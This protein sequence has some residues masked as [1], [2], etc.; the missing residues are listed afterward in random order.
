MFIGGFRCGITLGAGNAQLMRGGACA[1]EL[2]LMV[3]CVCCSSSGWYRLSWCGFC[4]CIFLFLVFGVLCV[5]WVFVY[6]VWGMGEESPSGRV[7][8]GYLR[9]V[10]ED[11]L[12]VGALE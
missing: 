7:C 3:G 12:C 5:F 2:C 8:L 10:Y 6:M 9:Y 1:A 4:G 11:L